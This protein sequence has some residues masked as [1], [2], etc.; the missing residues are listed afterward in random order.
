MV[1]MK[2]ASLPLIKLPALGLC[3][4]VT[5]FGMPAAA[6][7]SLPN[8]LLIVSDDQGRPVLGCMKLKEIPTPLVERSSRIRELGDPE[9]QPP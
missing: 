6:D 9:N 4:M 3:L 7:D 5:A 2:N 8:I 1:D